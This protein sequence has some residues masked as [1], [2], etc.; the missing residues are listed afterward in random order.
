MGRAVVHH[1]QATHKDFATVSITPLPA[2]ALHFPAIH[3]IV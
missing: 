3:E 1:Q 2:N